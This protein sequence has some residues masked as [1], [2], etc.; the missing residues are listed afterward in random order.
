MSEHENH[1]EGG[2]QEHAHKK[3]G[4][5]HGHAAA[6]AEHEE[7][8]PEWVVSFADNAL[9]QMGFFAILLAMNIGVKAKGAVDPKETK[10]GAA[11]AAQSDAYLDMV[12]AIREGFNSPVSM[13]S[14]NPEDQPLIKHLQKK[15]GKSP[16]KDGQGNGEA[17]DSQALKG[18]SITSENTTISFEQGSSSLSARGKGE[19]ASFARAVAGSN[20]V[21][22]VRGHVSPWEGR[23]A[24]Q[25]SEDIQKAHRLSFERALGVAGELVAAGCDV[26]LVR[27]RTSGS[28]DRVSQTVYTEAEKR[29]NQR[30]E[31][32]RTNEEMPADPF[33]KDPAQR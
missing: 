14:V 21:I 15:N 29:S 3:H 12:I 10:E 13:D 27:I 5:G 6:H 28:S 23:Q 2:G 17:P 30:V 20:F 9:L 16:G 33:T 24:Q 11:A 25:T 4:G 18:A 1:S 19:I 26:R 7:G 22:E 8:V 32:V 31:I